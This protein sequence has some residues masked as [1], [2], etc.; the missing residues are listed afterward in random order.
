MV[1]GY[2]EYIA[3]KKESFKHNVVNESLFICW[4]YHEDVDEI[5]NIVWIE[6]R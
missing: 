2:N 5:Y 4:Q 6:T 1:F 3:L